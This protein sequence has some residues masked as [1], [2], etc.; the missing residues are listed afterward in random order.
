MS[1][2]RLLVSAWRHRPRPIGDSRADIHVGLTFI[3]TRV[4]LNRQATTFNAFAF[5]YAWPDLS[6]LARRESVS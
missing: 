6:D 5:R 2:P 4:T 3:D 1:P